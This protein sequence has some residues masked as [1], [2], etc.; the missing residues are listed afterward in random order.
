MTRK[1]QATEAVA[2]LRGQTEPR[3]TPSRLLDE[4][5][6]IPIDLFTETF[7]TYFNKVALILRQRRRLP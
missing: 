4:I 1:E 3:K 6:A 7:N 2:F 5:E